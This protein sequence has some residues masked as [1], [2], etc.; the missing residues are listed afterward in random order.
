[1]SI[2][3]YPVCTCVCAMCTLLHIL[4]FLSFSLGPMTLLPEPLPPLPHPLTLHETIVERAL[5][6]A[7]LCLCSIC[8]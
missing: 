4:P 6:P 3:L 8:D 2:C 5:L 7:P 1:M